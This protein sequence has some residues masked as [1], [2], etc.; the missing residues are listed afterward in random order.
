MVGDDVDDHAQ[1]EGV[2]VGDQAVGLGEVTEARIDV[3]VVG[4][5]VAGVGLRRRVEGGEPHGVDAE[6]AEVGQA[7]ADAGEVAHAVAVG[8][9]EAADVDLVDDRVAPPR[10]VGRLGVHRGGL[11]GEWCL[12]HRCTLS[13]C[14]A[15]QRARCTQAPSCWASAAAARRR[16]VAPASS[17]SRRRAS[18]VGSSHAS[19]G[20]ASMAAAMASESGGRADRRRRRVDVALQLGDE[21]AE[22]SR[23]GVA[24]GLATAPGQGAE[25]HGQVV[26]CRA[27]HGLSL[28][29]RVPG[30]R[31]AKR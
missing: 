26:W 24:D 20:R 30:P 18:S 17:A 1:P 8:V 3:P 31:A 15:I 19:A 23:I 5:V 13:L 28:P 11:R 25:G 12:G 4:H 10:S 9:G 6:L 27:T 16:R 22:R 7:G 21:L 14:D 2:G 29:D